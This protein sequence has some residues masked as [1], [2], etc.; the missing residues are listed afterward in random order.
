MK[1]E[2][3]RVPSNYSLWGRRNFG[4]EDNPEIYAGIRFG[5]GNP[6]GMFGTGESVLVMVGGYKIK[7]KLKLVKGTTLSPSLGWWRYEV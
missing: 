5:Y 2:E 3:V 6:R 7:E 4:I 1:F